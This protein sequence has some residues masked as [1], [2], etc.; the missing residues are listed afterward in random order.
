M[1][2]ILLAIEEK[3]NVKI[4]DEEVERLDSINS[5][6]KLLDEKLK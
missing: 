2:N 1:A 6:V 5:I 4:H 3:Y